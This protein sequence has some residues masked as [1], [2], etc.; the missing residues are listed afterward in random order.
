MKNRRNLIMLVAFLLFG[1]CYGGWWAWQTQYLVPRKQLLDDIAKAEETQTQ[2]EIT[3]QSQKD[4]LARL[5]NQRFA[6]RSLPTGPPQGTA[7]T[8]YHSWLLEAGEACQFENLAVDSRGERRTQFYC[9]VVSFQLTAQTSLDQLSRFLYEFYWAPFLHR[10][11]SLSIVPV[12]N[13]DLVDI[14]LQIEGLVLYRNEPT[15]EFPYRD[16]LPEGY[17]QRLVS[18]RF[19]TY[20]GPI[21]SRNLLQFSR[22]GVDASD[23]AKLTGIVYVSGEP[24]FWINSQLENTVVRVKLDEPFRI[25]SFIGKIVEVADEDVIL[26]TSGTWNRPPMRWFLGKGE[27]L[28]DA[29]AVPEEF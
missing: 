29:M 2:Y 19:E 24:E 13:A 10:I 11:T 26:E 4:T 23:F 25:G 15:A 3:L 27:L 7:R 28:K 20:T 16:R 17:W 6:Q 18:G 9:S 12:E 5:E 8:L 22:S 14:T 1:V 21:E